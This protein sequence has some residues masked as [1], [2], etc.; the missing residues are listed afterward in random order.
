MVGNVALI[1]II[2][3]LAAAIT[4]CLSQATVAA[5]GAWLGRDMPGPALLTGAAP[6][7]LASA[8]MVTGLFAASRIAPGT[9]VLAVIGLAAAI[10]L[11]TYLSLSRR[12]PAVATVE[13]ID[14]S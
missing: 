10:Y 1:P 6:A 3:A 13:S 9:H 4:T 11:A 7:L 2:G 8:A 14:R 12:R 5:I